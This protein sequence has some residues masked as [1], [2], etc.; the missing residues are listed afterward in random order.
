MGAQ[1]DA[2]PAG[3]VEAITAS[4]VLTVNDHGKVLMLNVLTGATL[5]LPPVADADGMRVK[6]IVKLACTSNTYIITETT[7]SDTD[8][9]ISQVNELEVDTGD[10]GPS[11]T[12]HTTYTI[13][14]TGA[15]GDYVDAVCDGAK[16][17]LHGQAAADGAHVLA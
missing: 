11:S 9:L 12:G 6:I 10:D 13:G 14:T 2:S 16:W 1:F 4:K 5:T 7:A 17:Y 3:G 15:V 8:V